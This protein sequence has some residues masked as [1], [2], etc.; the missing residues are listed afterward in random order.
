M[1]RRSY[2]FS[3]TG[4]VR[5]IHPFAAVR[6]YTL[7]SVTQILNVVQSIL[8]APSVATQETYTESEDYSYGCSYG[9]FTYQAKSPPES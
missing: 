6:T 3:C 1:L 4:G 5:R 9:Y 8:N 7:C 2:R